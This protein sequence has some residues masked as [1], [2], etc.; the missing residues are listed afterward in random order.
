MD[1][2][3]DNQ[4]YLELFDSG[5][6]KWDNLM[7]ENE[8]DSLYSNGADVLG[9]AKEQLFGNGDNGSR[10]KVLHPSGT[11]SDG[12]IKVQYNPKT[13]HFTGSSEK[14]WKPDDD[15]DKEQPV[16][17]IT[18][19]GSLSM[20][21]ELVFDSTSPTDP[22]VRD[23]M[24]LLLSVMKKS[25]TKEAGFYWGKM[26]IRGRISSFQGEYLMF[27]PNGMPAAGSIRLTIQTQFRH[28]AGMKMLDAMAKDKSEQLA[29]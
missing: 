23:E 13:I 4:A 24:N 20:D 27:H 14:E 25:R 3:T 9:K 28:T 21:V 15:I 2:M 10:E 8:G 6:L 12:L 18:A 11:V 29:E 19:S 7:S 1:R 16:G 22:S 5:S 26:K 17:M